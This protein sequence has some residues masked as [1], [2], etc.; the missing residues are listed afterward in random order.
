[1]N[2]VQI[3]GG[4]VGSTGKIMFGISTVCTDEKQKTL[5]AAPEVSSGNKTGRNLY[6]IQNNNHRKINVLLD[7]IT[8]RHNMHSKIAT[9]RLLKVISGFKPDIIQLHNLHEAY[10]NLPM[11]FKYIKKHNIKTVWTLHDCWAFTGHCPY[12]DI[13]GCNKWKT[14]CYGCPQYK[15][16]PKSLFDNSKYMY[17]LKKKWFIGVENMTIV[18]PSEWLAGLVKESYLKDY[19]VKVINNG[20]DLNVF[21]PTESDFRKKYALENKYIVLGVA[22]GWGRRKGLDVFVELAERLDK[23]KY[24]IVLVGTDDNVDKLL[25]DNIISIHRTQSQTE[26]AE[27]YAAADVFANPTR[28][29]NYPTVNMEALACGTSVVTFNTGGSPEMLDETCGAAVA[30]DDTDAMYNEIV[31]ICETEPH[32]EESC[33]KK[34]RGFDMNERF[35]EYYDLYSCQ[36]KA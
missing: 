1:M 18:T 14:G 29:E 32:S 36:I 28:E 20:I 30:K 24:K 15:E 2:I 16:Y 4:A 3:N 34:A 23:G 26:L 11:L 35:K 9:E 25:P 6:I 5:C 8:G 10:I 19:P 31:R 17:R 27:I 33:L 21:K 12:F 13:V 22:F 7:R